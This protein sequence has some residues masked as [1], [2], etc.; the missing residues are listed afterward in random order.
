MGLPDLDLVW[1]GL[2]LWTCGPVDWFGQISEMTT[3]LSHLQTGQCDLARVQTNKMGETADASKP[4]I[5]Y[6]RTYAKPPFAIPPAF[7]GYQEPMVEEL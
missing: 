1:C 5:F 6:L 3:S 4:G 2:I 7:I